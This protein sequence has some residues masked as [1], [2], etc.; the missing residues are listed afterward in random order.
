MWSTVMAENNIKPNIEQAF[1]ITRKFNITPIKGFLNITWQN[2]SGPKSS[3]MM[4]KHVALLTH[5]LYKRRKNFTMQH[6]FHPIIT[7]F[8]SESL[9]TFRKSLFVETVSKIN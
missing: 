9:K 5:F 7:V 6:T 3:Y 1:R 4:K 8:P 2:K